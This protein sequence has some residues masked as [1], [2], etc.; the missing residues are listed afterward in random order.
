MIYERSLRE[1]KMLA[2]CN[3]EALENLMRL[4]QQ[5]RQGRQEDLLCRSR[6]DSMLDGDVMRHH[7]QH[8]D[9]KH[10]TSVRMQDLGFVHTASAQARRDREQLQDSLAGRRASLAKAHKLLRQKRSALEQRIIEL[11]HDRSVDE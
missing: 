11:E 5:L 1:T 9:Q 3:D 6:I 2:S 8:H 7:R 4:S 10:V